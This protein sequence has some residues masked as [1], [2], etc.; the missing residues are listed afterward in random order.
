[1]RGRFYILL[2]WT[3]QGSQRL[4]FPT[5][6]SITNNLLMLPFALLIVPLLCN[7]F[8]AVNEVESHNKSRQSYLALDKW[9]V[10]QCDRLRLCTTFAMVMTIT[11]CWKLFRYGVKRDHYEKLI[12]II[13][14]SE[15]LAQYFF[16]NTFHMIEGPQQI[17]YLPLM[18]LMMEIQFLLAVQF[19]F[20]V[21][22]L[23]P[24][25]SALFPT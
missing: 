24:Q 5:Y 22:F 19:S 12:S 18:S 23:P 3:T 15:R 14:L 16:N 1:M 7:F 17:T 20:L 21:V 10:N 4:V 8:S 13:E 9:W 6:L 25:L 2:L 11:N